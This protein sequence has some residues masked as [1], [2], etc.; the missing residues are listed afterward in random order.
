[1]KTA[2]F[3]SGGK[4]SY[5]CMRQL[6]GPLT[7]LSTL[8]EHS[9]RVPIQGIREEILI[10]QAA[11]C[12]HPLLRVPLPEL[13]DN[14]TYRERVIET[15]RQNGFERLVFGDIHLEDI[16]RFREDSFA[17]LG[18]SLEF[19]LWQ[20]NTASLAREMASGLAAVVCSV[21]PG[22]VDRLLLD[23]PYDARLLDALPADIDPCG[24]NGE[25]HTLVLGPAGGP[26]LEVEPMGVFEH[27]GHQVMDYGLSPTASLSASA[28]SI[29]SSSSGSS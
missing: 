13:C 26:R 8:D 21:N 15:I 28:A 11:A 14:A 6:S 10:A 3:F 12:G 19:P 17:D 2:L 25:F 18:V 23:H 7:L 5:W 20:R 9:R 4:D 22:R 29:R 1:M 24:E 27:L 16:R